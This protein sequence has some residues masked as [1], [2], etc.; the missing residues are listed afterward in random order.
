M[1]KTFYNP[2]AYS[3]IKEIEANYSSILKELNAIIDKPIEPDNYSTW[4]GERPD[5]L[6]NPVDKTVAWKTL[7]FRIFGID[8]QPNKDSCP[9]ICS[10]IDKYPFIVTAEF[11]LLEPYTHIHPHTGFTGKLL[12][13]HLGLIIPKGDAAIKVGEDV[14]KWEEGKV[15]V[16]DDSI[17]HEAWNNTNKKRVVFMFDFEPNLNES[18][19]KKVCY[20]V[21]SRTNDQH[22]MNI[23]PRSKWLEWLD[24][25]YFY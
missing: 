22:L 20:E 2:S 19:G 6:S 16:F 5:Y 10:I 13:S 24:A 18:I 15:M 7:T 23:A 4:I 3:F 12:R 17:K 14:V 25:G 1:N 9:T 8:Y 21:L 11:S